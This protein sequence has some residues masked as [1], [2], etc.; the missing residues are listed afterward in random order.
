MYPNTQH[1]IFHVNLEEL[2]R[3]IP[4]VIYHL[5]T[6][7]AALIRSALPMY[8][9]TSKIDFETGLLLT[10]EGGDELFG[11]YDYLKDLPK[12]KL[13]NE[14]VNMLKKEHATGL[15]CVDRI[16]YAF[17]LEARAPWFDTV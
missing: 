5:E 2:L 14:F 11:G 8:Y 4:E 6:F 3:I 10:G 13:Q 12:S 1:H 16:P 7:D 15:Q 9:V 17:Q